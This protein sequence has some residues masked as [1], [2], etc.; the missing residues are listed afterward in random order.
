[1]KPGHERAGLL[2]T[3]AVAAVL[4]ATLTPASPNVPT[5]GPWC[6]LCG[7]AG[8]IDALQ[9]VVLFLPFG[10]GLAW[11]GWHRVGTVWTAFALSAFVETMQFT[12]IPG[13]DASLGDL[14][15][16]SVGGLLGFALQ[17]ANVNLL[18]PGRAAAV[19]LQ[20]LAGTAWTL[21]LLIATFGL[22]P[23]SPPGPA[24]HW[25]FTAPFDSADARFFSGSLSAIH[26]NGVRLLV[27]DP[28]TLSRGRSELGARP[29]AITVEIQP[30]QPTSEYATIFA[31]HAGK[32]H[33]FSFG[34]SGTD[35]LCQRFLV[36][37]AL[38]L[39]TPVFVLA[40][41]FPSGAPRA[42]EPDEKYLLH[43]RWTDG[44]M[45]LSRTSVADS[46]AISV[47]LTPGLGWALLVPSVL[48]ESRTLTRALSFLW[49]VLIAAPLG[50]WSRIPRRLEAP[51]ASS[52]LRTPAVAWV[53]TLMTLT[54]LLIAQ[55][56][57][58]VIAG[59]STSP[60]EEYFGTG[61]GFLLGVA[62]AHLMRQLHPPT[63][64]S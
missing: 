50:F 19:G 23:A 41:A 5:S 42:E 12:L 64:G 2:V 58:P 47:P 34:Q 1:M 43:C 60:L 32:V 61:I 28:N 25:T 55:Y 11:R 53:A 21:A 54:A 31:V 33:P 24:E 3:V 26:V 39:R 9:N 49:L 40:G 8:T 56:G 7:Q 27:S 10:F 17:T 52:P 6:V 59:T 20:A 51:I 63:I 4:I 46:T 14:L 30:G 35:L 29:S 37:S 48:G 57:A 18:R 13:R 22:R 36:A 38:L 16:N 62:L 15:F 44:R 45:I